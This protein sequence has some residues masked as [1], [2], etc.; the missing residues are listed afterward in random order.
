MSMPK[1]LASAFLPTGRQVLPTKNLEFALMNE[2]ATFFFGFN[3]KE[4]LWDTLQE[5]KTS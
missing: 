5:K 4:V 3:L 2:G 1:G